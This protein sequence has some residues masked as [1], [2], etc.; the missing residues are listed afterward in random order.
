QKKVYQ[1]LKYFPHCSLTT[2]SWFSRPWLPLSGFRGQSNILF[3]RTI[4]SQLLSTVF[5]LY[6]FL[7]VA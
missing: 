4:E 3:L 5:L 1:F 2:I 6:I 7:G